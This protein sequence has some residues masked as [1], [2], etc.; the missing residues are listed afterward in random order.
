MPALVAHVDMDAFF[1]SLEIRSDPRLADRP[2]V[3][4]GGP[5]GRGVVTTASYPARRFGIHSG[6]SLAEARRRCPG[7]LALPV[8]PPKVM[9]ESLRVLAVLESLA[10]RVEAASVDEAYLD[11][12]PVAPEA[13]E[14]VAR[15]WGLH[16]RKRVTAATGLSCSV[17]LAVNKLQA[18]MATPLGKPEG[19]TVLPQDAF[20]ATFGEREVSVIPGIGPRTTR[21]LGDLGIRT[22]ADLARAEPERLRTVF[23]R[24]SSVLVDQA[25]GRG[26]GTVVASGEEPPP[27]SAGHETTF[28]RDRADPRFLR[29]TL[30]YLADRVARRLRRHGFAA[31]TVVVR[32]K[33]GLS[34]YSRQRS[35]RVPTDLP[36]TLAAEGWRL[37][38]PARAGRPLRLLGIAG[39]GLVPTAPQGVLFP[40]DGRR[41]GVLGAGDLLRDRFGEDALLPGTVFLTGRER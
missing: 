33:V 23:G 29:A 41:R 22:V 14:A 39:A 10:A 1:A 34:R 37:L 19:V 31:R 11:L 38:E 28:A 5:S 12:P 7:L 18:K 9:H 26:G 27:K 2:L 8:D 17:G 6:M 16:I 15:T 40:E 35:L 20:L 30:W 13:W 24:G 25:G 4:G 21:A 32:Y 36:G 3:V